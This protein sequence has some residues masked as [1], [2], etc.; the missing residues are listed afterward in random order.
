MGTW[1]FGVLQDDTGADVHADYM[2][3]LNAGKM[4]GEILV[5]I[6]RRYAEAL[7]DS[8]DGP[9]AWLAIAKAQWECGHLSPEIL[10]HVENI[11][12]KG[13]G[14]GLWEDAGPKGVERRHKALETFLAKLRTKNERPKK[15]RKP[16]VRKPIFQTGDCLAVRLSDGDHGAAIVLGYP[17]EKIRPGGDTYGINLIGLLRYKSAERPGP[18]T[19]E[20]REWLRLT[21]HSWDGRLELLKAMALRFRSYK[22]RFE[23]VGQTQIRP[24]DPKEAPAYS[25][26]EFGEQMVHQARWERGE[27]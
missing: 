12:S 2:E 6:K 13:E 22:D 1:G 8:D 9:V 18:D 26:W 17:A 19:F 5:E 7:E 10:A 16:I 20:K 14:L 23:V 25:G 11:V 27:R 3:L 4:P 24:E 15:P 21:H